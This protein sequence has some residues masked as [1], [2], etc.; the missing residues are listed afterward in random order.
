MSQMIASI[1][2]MVNIMSTETYGS[3]EFSTTFAGDGCCMRW[4]MADDFFQRQQALHWT[5]FLARQ[6]ASAPELHVPPLNGI[7]MLLFPLSVAGGTAGVPDEVHEWVI[8]TL[9][10]IG[11]TMGIQRAIEMIPQ[12]KKT[13][14]AME[15]RPGAVATEI[16][17][18]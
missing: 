5:R 12:L 6:L 4:P 1:P 8:S 18:T 17:F 15:N 13:H 16:Y 3:Q 2:F 14:G 10:R 9:E 11:R 7:F